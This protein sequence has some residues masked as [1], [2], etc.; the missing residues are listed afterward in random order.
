MNSS[1]YC[2]RCGC[3]SKHYSTRIAG[4]VCDQCGHPVIEEGD[5]NQRK[6]YDKTVLLA[7][8][9]IRVA[10]YSEAKKLVIPLCSQRPADAQLYIM[11]FECVTQ[12]Y[13]DLLLHNT[14]A[15]R[16]AEGYWDKLMNLDSITPQMQCYQRQ[17][18]RVMR[19]E[20]RIQCEKNEI[21]ILIISLVAL[22]IPVV[23]RFGFWIKTVYITT[24]VLL[25]IVLLC[26]HPFHTLKRY[27]YL[28][29]NRYENPFSYRC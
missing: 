4:Y 27:L 29:R 20:V 6:N 12:K 24:V 19:D 7:K 9:H 1:W 8:E 22:L 13:E 3:S 25:I 26:N 21:L 14:V 18:E 10:N 23:V 2:L 17:R 16:E 15:Q 11:L 28:D 5:E